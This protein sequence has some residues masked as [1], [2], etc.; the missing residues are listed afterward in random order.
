MEN[1]QASVPDHIKE[2]PLAELLIR[3]SIAAADATPFV[4]H[5][6]LDDARKS[7][8]STSFKQFLRGDASRIPEAFRRWP[9]TTLWNFA[10]AL[11]QD[12]GEDGHAVYAVLDRA[13][14]VNIP[15][16]GDLRSKI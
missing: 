8:F 13:F 11:S 4:A 9:L 5:C 7:R 14:G 2:L 15:G 12:Y 1:Q 6:E 3:R 16:V 10:L